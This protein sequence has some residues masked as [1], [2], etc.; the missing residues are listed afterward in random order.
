[1]FELDD[2]GSFTGP[3]TAFIKESTVYES[4]WRMMIWNLA[5]WLVFALYLYTLKG[6]GSEDL[7]CRERASKGYF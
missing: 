3:N 5:G 7:G 4:T 1:M 2:V 6:E